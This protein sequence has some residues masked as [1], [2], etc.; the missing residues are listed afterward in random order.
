[1]GLIV[2]AVSFGAMY[3]LFIRPQQRRMREHQ[4]MIAALE[5]GDEVMTNGGVYGT[6][7]QVDQAV[8]MLEIADGLEIRVNR[9]SI[10]E[11]VTFDPDDD[12][13]VDPQA[14]NERPSLGK[15]FGLGRGED[16]PAGTSPISD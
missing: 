9:S 4:E 2:I 14:D 10:A 1:M 13:A 16:P 5:A 11:L 12:E 7:T 6:I 8:V 3:L 15:L